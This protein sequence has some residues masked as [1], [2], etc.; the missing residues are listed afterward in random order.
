[1]SNDGLNAARI[2][3]KDEFYTQ[4]TDIEK[5]LKNYEI[6]FKDKTVFCNCDDPEESN[7]W[8][9]FEINFDHLGLKKL[10]ST[11]Y[12]EASPTYKQE[13]FV[14][15]NGEKKFIKTNLK[16][17]GDFRSSESVAILAESDICVTNPPFSLFREFI[18]QLV[19]LNKQFLV[20]G[21]INAV[22]AKEIFPLIKDKKLWL[23]QSIR[24]GDREFRVPSN[25]PLQATGYRVDEDGNKYIR[26]K[27][28]RWF[29]NLDYPERHKDINLYQK[30]YEEKSKYPSYDNFDAI[31]VGK[32]KEIPCDYTGVMGV[33]IT[34]L[35]KYNPNQFEIVMLANG[36]ART[37]VPL[38][39]LQ[40]VN[41]RPHI[42]DRGGV[43]I[44]NN[45]RL[46]A[47]ILIRRKVL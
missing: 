9:Y 20:I 16:Q 43:G 22:T 41:Y 7:F 12:R 32:V 8:R 18:T 31:E 5:E 24:S 39:T 30:Y 40:E 34:F 47:R 19:E 15:E 45:K 2:A 46:Y 4:M 26:V 37:N 29:T 1:M 35:D 6:Y 42:E 10:I 28:I 11:H 38:K 25:Y 33:P 44:I 17:N 23:G 21:Q 36:N 14:N 27:G 13:L 3:K